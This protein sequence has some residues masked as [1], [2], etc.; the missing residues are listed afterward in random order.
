MKTN[1]M[2]EILQADMN[3][4]E[5]WPPTFGN[6]VFASLIHSDFVWFIS[7][8]KAIQN[9]KTHMEKGNYCKLR[10]GRGFNKHLRASSV[11]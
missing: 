9:H 2:Q 6:L 1:M 5:E 11:F 8:A 4:Y 10:A 7:N 3:P